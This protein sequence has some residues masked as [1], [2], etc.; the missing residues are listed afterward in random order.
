MFTDKYDLRKSNINH[1]IFSEQYQG[2]RTQILITTTSSMLILLLTIPI[3]YYLFFIFSAFKFCPHVFQFFSVHFW[4]FCPILSPKIIIF[5][6]EV[7]VFIAFEQGSVSEKCSKSS[8][9]E[10][11]FC[12][13]PLLM[14]ARH[15][16]QGSRYFSSSL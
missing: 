1:Y 10:N 12:L 8:L 6:T 3:Y 14:I 15:R 16:L 4:F 5:F 9:S 13:L 2:S 11:A 7:Y